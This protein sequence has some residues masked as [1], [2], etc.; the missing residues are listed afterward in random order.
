[1]GQIASVNFEADWSAPSA[2]KPNDLSDAERRPGVGYQR[3]LRLYI[4]ALLTAAYGMS[5]A[6]AEQYAD[7]NG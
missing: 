2:P 5:T 6:N 4:R 3:R 7:R 1:M